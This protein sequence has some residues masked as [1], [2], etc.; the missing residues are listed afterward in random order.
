MNVQNILTVLLAAMFATLGVAKML[1]IPSMRERAAHVGFSAAAYR[2]IGALEVAAAV[3]LTGGGIFPLISLAAAGGLLLLLVGAVVAHVR[4]GDRLNSA[5]PAVVLGLLL[6]ILL[7]L[8]L[9]RW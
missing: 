7:V 3:G 6:V 9:E 4:A 8:R 5:S 1:A 2:R